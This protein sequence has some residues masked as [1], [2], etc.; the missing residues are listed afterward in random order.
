MLND[1]LEIISKTK[2]NENCVKKIIFVFFDIRLHL[3]LLFLFSY[4]KT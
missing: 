2:I 1:K 4:T 3:C